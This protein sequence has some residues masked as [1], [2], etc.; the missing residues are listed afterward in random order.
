ML[1]ASEKGGDVVSN[2]ETNP[3]KKWFSRRIN[4]FENSGGAKSLVSS[5]WYSVS[6][7]VSDSR[8]VIVMYIYTGLTS[9]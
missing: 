4:R 7:S 9:A 3:G 5:F 6:C 2:D 8:I 1:A